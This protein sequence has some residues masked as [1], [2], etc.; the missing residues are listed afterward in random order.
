MRADL[1]HDPSLPDAFRDAVTAMRNGLKRGR[2]APPRSRC[3]MIE[4]T[5]RDFLTVCREH[6][7]PPRIDGTTGDAFE[8]S[9]RTQG[10]PLKSIQTI[11]SDL[12]FFARYSGLGKDWADETGLRTETA[13]EMLSG[14]HWRPHKD[15]IVALLE[16][17][18]SRHDL[19]L[20]DEWLV[21]RPRVLTEEKVEAFVGGS[22]KRANR[23]AAALYR[24]EP[25]GTDQIVVEKV[26]LQHNRRNYR[27]T[28]TGRRGKAAELSV[29]SDDLPEAVRSVLDE[30][31][32]PPDRL[33][34]PYSNETVTSIQ[35]VMRQIVFHARSNGLGDAIT[36]ELL[37]S[38]LDELDRRPIRSA[39]R[40]SHI[41]R[42]KMFARAAGLDLD[43][44]R[45]L[46]AER[47]Y[48]GHRAS[49]EI[50][51]KRQRL[52][53]TPAAL[54]DLALGARSAF[55]AAGQA[56]THRSRRELYLKAAALALLSVVPLR[57]K[58]MMRLTFGS[59]LVRTTAG[60]E[61]RIV[62]S[63]TG[64]SIDARLDDHLTPYL[65]HAVSFGAQ[66]DFWSML[67]EVDGLP[68]FRD[69][70]GKRLTA[71]WLYL[72][73]RDATGHGP[74]IARTL[75]HDRSDAFGPIG[76]DVAMAL[77]GQRDH[78]VAQRHY[79]VTAARKRVR[80]VQNVLQELS[81]AEAVS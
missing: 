66:N 28:P 57:A 75:M 7:W 74:H 25:D 68:I 55:M 19:I 56:R 63:K 8:R 79:E 65:D 52:A 51:R 22:A 18:L 23:L 11:M 53:E 49:G 16:E 42:I 70:S 9:L 33:R 1:L 24:L 38:Y 48:Y 71:V 72:A 37:S 46:G 30:M 26:R 54:E 35:H 61:L 31:L 27:H 44:Q 67:D 34:R 10:R 32:R 80:T 73:A 76:R 39:T 60:W 77:C 29:L 69:L 36:P 20:L 14:R 58:D 78:V 5:I 59:A 43:I 17:G 21:F 15:R 12:R 62:T 40:A 64:V 2:E 6:G 3:V 13:A 81:T 50:S 4:K 41:N 45:K 47:D